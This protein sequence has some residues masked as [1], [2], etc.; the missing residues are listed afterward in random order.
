MTEFNFDDFIASFERKTTPEKDFLESIYEKN[1]WENFLISNSNYQITPELKDAFHLLWIEKG[2][3]LREKLNNDKK[4]VELLKTLLPIYSGD[5]MVLYRGE[6]LRRYQANRMGFCWTTEI[7]VARKFASGLNAYKSGGILLRAEIESSSILAGLHPHSVYLEENEITV[8]PFC[9][10][11][12]KILERF[13][14]WK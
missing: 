9:I 1:L 11:N 10:K 12:I 13:P 5:G 6:N 2:H 7:G 3:F 14:S 4:L 8:N